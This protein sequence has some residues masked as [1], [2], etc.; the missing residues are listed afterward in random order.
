[1]IEQQVGREQDS[2]IIA[3]PMADAGEESAC[4]HGSRHRNYAAG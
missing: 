3:M 4:L 2:L 1:M